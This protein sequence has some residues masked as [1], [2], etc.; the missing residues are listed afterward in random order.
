MVMMAGSLRL[1]GALQ[2]GERRLR[3]RGI[4]RGY[5]A[6]KSRYALLN[7]GVSRAG[8]LGGIALY[9]GQ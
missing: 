8:T 4:S 2:F 9:L 3:R 6:A 7:G 5:R 1:H